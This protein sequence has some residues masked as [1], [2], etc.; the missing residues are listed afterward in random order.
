MKMKLFYRTLEQAYENNPNCKITESD[1][2]EYLKYVEK[3]K[4]NIIETKLDYRKREIHKIKVDY[5]F[6]FLRFYE[7]D[8][9]YLDGLDFQVWDNNRM[10]SP[11]TWTAGEPEEFY[12][13][14]I[15]TKNMNYK[16]YSFRKYGQP[17]LAK[18]KELKGVKQCFS[19]DYIP[20]KCKCQCFIK[21]DDLYIKHKD[22][23]S[24]SLKDSKE[25]FGNP[26]EYMIKKYEIN[27]KK[28]S[29]FVYNDCWGD[30]VL[31]NEAWIVLENVIPQIKLKHEQVLTRDLI[32]KFADC[33]HHRMRW[34]DV[35]VTWNLFWEN[36]VKELYKIDID[37]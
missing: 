9:I 26:L 36:I 4:N 30:I 27:S 5:G 15:K 29:G 23:F 34:T 22:Y 3:I 32:Q 16:I 25:D 11:I 28:N 6:I 17:K 12:N 24:E 7:Q 18:P 19:V 10:I 31:R 35:D 8:G 37:K 2:Y 13:E 33:K 14:Y 20:K 1:D 21:D